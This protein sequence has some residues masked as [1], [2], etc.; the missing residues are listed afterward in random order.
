MG[1]VKFC[2]SRIFKKLT[3]KTRLAILLK[4]FPSFTYTAVIHSVK[5]QPPENKQKRL[6]LYVVIQ[7]ERKFAFYDT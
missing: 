4:T 5:K 7:V 1:D 3:I 2:N 6:I